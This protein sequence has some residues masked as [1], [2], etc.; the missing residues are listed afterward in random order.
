MISCEDVTF[1]YPGRED[2]PALE[3]ISLEIYGGEFVAISGLNGSGKSTLCRLFNALL[4]PVRGKVVSCGLD[5]AEPGHLP[6]IRR[7]VGL[8]M[9]NPDNQIVGPTVEDDVAFG[10]ENIALPRDE[11]SLRVGEALESMRLT[12]L[13]G[14]E[15]HLLSL[16]EKKRLSIAGVMALR[17]RVLVSDEST[18]MLDP[19]TRAETIA[20]FK[21]LRDELGITVIH[22]THRPEEILAADRV[23]LLGG[24][25]LLFLGPPQGLFEHAELSREHGLRPTAL[26]LLARELERRGYPLAGVA[27]DTREMAEGLWALR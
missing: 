7:Q 25:R 15:P 4:L 18:S 6:E 3:G 12:S 13:R 27:M 19:P 14:R 11:I 26:H 22:A 5:T 8:I 24:G 21:R 1:T 9:Q 2:A 23:A 20:L 16:G 10:P 17:P